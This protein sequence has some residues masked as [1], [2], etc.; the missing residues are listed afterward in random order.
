MIDASTLE[1]LEKEEL[2]DVS[3]GVLVD[4]VEYQ[5][6]KGFWECMDM[7]KF[8]SLGYRHE[9]QCQACI[10]F[11]PNAGYS[12]IYFAEGYCDAIIVS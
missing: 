3:G 5:C 11:R 4:G 6:A 2:E 10:H 12:D 1:K 9:R 7:S 8:Q